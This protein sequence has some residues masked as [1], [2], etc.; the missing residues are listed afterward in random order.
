MTQKGEYSGYADW[1]FI[2]LTNYT[3]ITMTVAL[4]T[5]SDRYI[6]SVLLVNYFKH[7]KKMRAITNTH[8]IITAFFTNKKIQDWINGSSYIHTFISSGIVQP[9]IYLHTTLCCIKTKFL[10]KTEHTTSTIEI[11]LHNISW[12]IVYL[13]SISIDGNL[14]GL[15]SEHQI[16]FSFFVNWLLYVGRFKQLWNRRREST[17]EFIAE[18]F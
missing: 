14:T 18:S 13:Q 12:S 2:L 4:Y 8:G 16:Q 15:H 7:R 17:W 1:Y 5:Y 3:R 10:L 9:G 11:R 6:S